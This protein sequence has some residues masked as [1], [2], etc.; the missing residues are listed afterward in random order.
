MNCPACRS[1][2]SSI[3]PSRAIQSLIDTY[4]RCVP[5]RARVAREKEQA[6]EIYAAGQGIPVGPYVVLEVSSLRLESQVPAVRARSP[7][8]VAPMDNDAYYRPCPHC[9]SANDFNWACP[10]PIIDPSVDP[11]RARL[12]T[13]GIPPGHAKCGNCEHLHATRAPTTSRCDFCFQ[14]FCGLVSPTR[15][16]AKRIGEARPGGVETLPDI[17]VN[18]DV[19]NAFGIN[20]VEFDYMLDYLREHD[21]NP[22][23]IYAEVRDFASFVLLFLMSTKDSRAIGLTGRRLATFVGQRAI[24]SSHRTC[25]RGNFPATTCQPSFSPRV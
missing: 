2:V 6:D 12:L 8:I 20:A 9:P 7:D 22:R 24:S 16:H 11:N 25:C 21:I 18:T 17:L 5:S 15:C 19:Y 4:L 23:F 1:P 3:V 10:E 13:D 14:S